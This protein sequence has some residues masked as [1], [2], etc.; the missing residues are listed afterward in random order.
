[1]VAPGFAPGVGCADVKHGRNDVCVRPH[2]DQQP[3]NLTNLSGTSVAA[4]V[5][6][7]MD[8]FDDTMLVAT[9]SIH[10]LRNCDDR[11]PGHST[12]RRFDQ[13]GPDIIH[14]VCP[15][16]DNRGHI[17]SHRGLTVEGSCEMS[18]GKHLLASAFVK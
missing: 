15:R 9:Q 17:A 10:L 5:V 6:T 2:Q 3:T 16:D 12:L 4:G 8:A 1:L 14:L 11:F 18:G 7:G 13:I